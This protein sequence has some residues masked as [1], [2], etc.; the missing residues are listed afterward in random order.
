MGRVEVIARVER[1]RRWTEDEKAALLAEIEEPGSGVAVVARRHG[2]A[3]SLLY[4]WRSAR[5]ARMAALTF[6][7]LGVIGDI[8]PTPPALPPPE[9]RP[10]AKPPRE[11][12]MMEIEL[13]GGTRVRVDRSV[14]G[15]ALRRLL[16]AMKGV[17]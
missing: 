14:D 11:S 17:L 8:A 12:G 9:A 5:K 15:R 3:E 13:P 1:R 7:P 16:R 4:N 6:V 2:V 10:A